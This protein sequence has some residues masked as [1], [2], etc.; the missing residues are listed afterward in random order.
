MKEIEQIILATS[1]IPLPKRTVLNISYTSIVIKDS[2][3]TLLKAFE[4]SIEQFN[5]LRILRGQKDSLSALYVKRIAER[6]KFL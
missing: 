6:L 3:A 5:V 1:L 2:I 4:I